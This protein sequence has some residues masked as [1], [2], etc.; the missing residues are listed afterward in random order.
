[1][2]SAADQELGALRI[3]LLQA[4]AEVERMQ[5]LQQLDSIGGRTRGV[6]GVASAIVGRHRLSNRALNLAAA[7]IGFARRQSWLLP[8]VASVSTRLL[9][10]RA[11]RWLLFAGAAG[12]TLW[13]ARQASAT[14]DTVAECDSAD[15]TPNETDETDTSHTATAEAARLYG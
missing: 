9:R 10:S 4:R 11:L 12:A 6:R 2:T 1:M 3:E 7:A 8:A 15:D 13:L 5:L 14:G